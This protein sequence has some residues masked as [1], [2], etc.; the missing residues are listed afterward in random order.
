MCGFL[1]Y[2]NKGNNFYI[3]KRGQDLTNKVNINGLTFVHNLLHVTGAL[4]PQPFIKDGIVCV[5]NGE[6]YNHMYNNSDGENIIPLYEKHGVNFVK[7]LDGEWAIALYDFNKKLAIFAANLFATKPLWRKGLECASYGSG[8]GGHKI[9]AN[10]IDVVYFDGSEES[11]R[12]YDWDL[13]QHKGT[14]DDWITTFEKAVAKRAVDNCFLGVSSGYDSGAICCSLQ[15][16]ST[17]FKAYII[18]AQEDKKVLNQR[19]KLI[20]D[21]QL[22]NS[23]FRDELDWLKQNVEEFRYKLSTKKD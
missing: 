7:H 9:P 17:N 20:N 2:K 19:M 4:T 16:L 10:T 18:E 11:K 12:I 22:F 6:I 8:V 1:V 15:N 14:Y 13:N 23:G 3:Q 5:Y 21:Y